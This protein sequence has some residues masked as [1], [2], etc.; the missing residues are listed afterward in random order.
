MQMLIANSALYLN[1]H[2]NEPR[3]FIAVDIS[4]MM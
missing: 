4:W 2:V 1:Q 3:H